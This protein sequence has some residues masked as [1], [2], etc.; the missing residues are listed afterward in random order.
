MA[1]QKFKKRTM[2]EEIVQEILKMIQRGEYR[3]GDQIPSE[4]ELMERMNV[5]RSSIRE[6]L[7]ALSVM[8][9]ISIHPGRRTYVTSLAPDLLMEHLEFVIGL[10]DETLLQLF[11]SRKLLEVGC[12]SLAAERISDEEIQ[13]LEKIIQQDNFYDM[14]I[15][16]HRKIVEITKNPIIRRVYSS[17]EKLGEMSRKRTAQLPGVRDQSRKDHEKIVEAIIARDP[18]AA[19]DAMMQHLTFVEEQ[20]KINI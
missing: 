12:A 18:N 4:I 10:E 6:A 13:E 1:F 7:R 9:V 2:S 15:Q 3:P 8:N 19:R 11:E 20:L 17:I 14:D 16:L 5:S